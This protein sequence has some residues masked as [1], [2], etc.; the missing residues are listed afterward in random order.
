MIKYFALCGA[1]EAG[2]S[3][4]QSIL[5]TLFDVTPIDDSRGL[6][7]AAKIL[8][9]L[10]ESD[11]TT[12]EGKRRLVQVGDRMIPVREILGELGN[13][14]EKGDPL[15]IPR[16]ARRHAEQQH[17]GRRVSFGSVRMSQGQLFKDSESIVVEVSRPGISPKN[18]FDFYDTKLVDVTILNTYDPEDPE[19]STLRLVEEVK[20]KISPFLDQ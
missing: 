3:K 19:A 5:S 8:Y 7:D 6:R 15:H 17:P 18:Q 13:Y 20:D 9:G 14:L 10:N 12:Q 11:V 4:V 2:K 16:M 1:P